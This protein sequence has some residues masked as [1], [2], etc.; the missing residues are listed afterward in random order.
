MG[1]STGYTDPFATLGLPPTAS[2]AEA[3]AAFRKLALK[4][5]PDVDPSPSAAS[6]FSEI[7]RATD[8]ILKGVRV[9]QWTVPLADQH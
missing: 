9:G 1:S 2:K 5:H 6:R 3:K 8:M 7:K 4:C